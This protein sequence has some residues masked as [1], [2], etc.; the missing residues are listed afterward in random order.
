MSEIRKTLNITSGTYYEIKGQVPF[1]NV[2]I[3]LGN[4]KEL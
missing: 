1:L 4:Q 3:I 2:G